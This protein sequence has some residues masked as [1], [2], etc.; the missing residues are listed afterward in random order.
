VK[1]DIDYWIGELVIMTA[2]Y[3]GLP[4]SLGRRLREAFRKQDMIPPGE[5][6]QSEQDKTINNAII[7][8]HNDL[9]RIGR[10]PRNGESKLGSTDFDKAT[11]EFLKQ[12]RARFTGHSWWGWLTQ[13][14]KARI[15]K[16]PRRRKVHWRRPVTKVGPT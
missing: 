10:K 11:K 6:L 12:Q 7:Y 16:P 13:Q 1:A 8:W 2:P 9:A 4:D 5:K 3:F 15:P 14:L